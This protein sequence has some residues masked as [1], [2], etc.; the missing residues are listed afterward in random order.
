[1][2]KDKKRKQRNPLLKHNIA[3]LVAQRCHHSNVSWMYF[4]MWV[5]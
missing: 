5:D 2:E 1:M 4:V 3:C